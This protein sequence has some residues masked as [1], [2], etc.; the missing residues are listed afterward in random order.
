VLESEYNKEMSMSEGLPVA[1]KAI[2]SA[3]KRDVYTG[4]SFDVVTITK[5]KGY[6]ELSE[7]EKKV[8]LNLK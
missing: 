1:I 7:K 2:N 6:V 5:E 3:I 8:Y 4:D